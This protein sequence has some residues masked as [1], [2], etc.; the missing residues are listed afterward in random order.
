MYSTANG[1][2]LKI[3]TIAALQENYT[4][5][6]EKFE[7]VA[8]ESMKNTLSRYSVK[9]YLFKASLCNLA[10]QDLHDCKASLQQ[11]I[12]LDSSFASAREAKF[13]HVRLLE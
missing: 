8:K 9:E 5:A 4:L 2:F 7:E 3:A 6:I 1:I 12:A 13:I 10:S 11:Y